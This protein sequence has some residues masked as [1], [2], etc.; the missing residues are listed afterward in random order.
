[1]ATTKIN[2]NGQEVELPEGWTLERYLKLTG[3]FMNSAVQG[4]K[5]DQAVQEA[6]KALKK[7]YP[8]EFKTLLNAELKK[9]GLPVKS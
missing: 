6:V 5:R 9:V 4:K 1:M 8:A 2:V 3:A 7:K